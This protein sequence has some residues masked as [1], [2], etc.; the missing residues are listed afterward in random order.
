MI[1]KNLTKEVIL[2]SK[3]EDVIAGQQMKNE[4]KGCSSVW[5]YHVEGSDMTCIF[6]K[7]A[8]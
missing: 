3:L 4:G 2:E 7:Q 5:K 6:E 8:S 1:M